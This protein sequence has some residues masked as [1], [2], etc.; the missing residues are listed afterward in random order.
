MIHQPTDPTPAEIRRRCAEIR[1]G[2]SE[3][4]RE[5]RRVHPVEDWTAPVVEYLPHEQHG[6][7][8]TDNN[9]V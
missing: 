6:T 8:E 1:A 2:W 9:H 4:E 5:R 3:A 7:D